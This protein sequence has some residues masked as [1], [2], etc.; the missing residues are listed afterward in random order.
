MEARV[1]RYS[2]ADANDWGGG[3]GRQGPGAA[4]VMALATA[5]AVAGSDDRPASNVARKPEGSCMRLLSSS[6]MI[7]NQVAS[8]LLWEAAGWWHGSDYGLEY[9]HK[10]TWR[11]RQRHTR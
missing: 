3:G 1:A 2:Q 11:R 7:S 10:Q 9:Q 8:S 4:G 5:A 6:C